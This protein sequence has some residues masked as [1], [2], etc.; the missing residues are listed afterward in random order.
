VKPPYGNQSLAVS[1]LNTYV[2][3][4]VLVLHAVPIG[5]AAPGGRPVALG[6]A[7]VQL[8]AGRST[9]ANRRHDQAQPGDLERRL[10][11]LLDGTRDRVALVD[12]LTELALAKELTV[13]Q[14]GQDGQDVTDPAAVREAMA[15]VLERSLEALAEASLL[16]G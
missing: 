7:R 10:I 13:R 16:V 6:S 12:R 4:D 1:M 11:P 14:D 15:G 9:V 8:L 2:A 5:A 3:S